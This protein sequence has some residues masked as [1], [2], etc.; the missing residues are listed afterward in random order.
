MTIELDALVIGAGIAGASIGAELASDRRV[1][2]LERES[3]PGYHSTGRSAALFSESY[4]NAAVRALSRASRSFLFDPPA[5]FIDVPLTRARGTVHI[6]NRDNLAALEALQ[7]EHD[8]AAHTERLDGDAVRALAPILTGD[9]VA[10][11]YERHA[12]DVDVHALHQAYLRLLRARG[13]VLRTDVVPHAIG[14]GTGSLSDRW[15]VET[16]DERFVTPLLVNAGGAWADEIAALA[17][18]RQIGLEPKRRTALLLDAPAG[19]AIEDWPMVIDVDESFYF[20]PDAGLLLVS[21][22][23]ETPTPPCDAQPDEMDVAIAVERY[24]QATTERVRRVSHRWAG[25][26]SFVADRSPVI[27]FAA[28]APG[29]FWLAA[30]GGYGIQTAP[31]LAQTA[32]ALAR[33][34]PLPAAIEEEGVS[35]SDLSPARF[36][37]P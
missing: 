23:D 19:H 1:L 17:G 8:F 3:Q 12:R 27:G 30:Q 4:G 37:S 18:V 11:L 25:L 32:G 36:A 14:R 35:A 10:G 24:E 9:W 26:R 33:G 13:G 7:A 20:K 6:A 22:A 28:D 15:I 5:G 29:F 21:P 2:V 34:N 31:A 16:A